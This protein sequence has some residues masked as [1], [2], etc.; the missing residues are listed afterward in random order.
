MKLTT[1]LALTTLISLPC[2][3]K[4]FD[5]PVLKNG[6]LVATVADY[7]N[8]W[9]RDVSF[10][11]RAS[12]ESAYRAETYDQEVIALKRAI[13]KTLDTLNPKFNFYLDA[14]L[15]LSIKVETKL[16]TPKEKA[17]FLRRSVEAALD[18][19]HYLDQRMS[20]RFS[21]DHEAYVQ[22]VLNRIS[23]E[24][25]RAKTDAVETMILKTGAQSAIEILADSDFRRASSNA[26]AVKNLKEIL[27]EEDVQFMRSLMNQAISS[28]SRGCY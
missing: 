3:A 24:S 23:D 15:A 11:L 5:S 7:E 6:E 16:T 27:K 14:T 20:N 9:C 18:D 8:K 25:F 22:V 28:L 17:Q 19:L 12:I 13:N 26:C 1:V 4:S 10:I 21:N 2:L